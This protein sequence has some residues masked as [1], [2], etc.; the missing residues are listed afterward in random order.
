M[1]CDVR[2]VVCKMEYDLVLRFANII[3]KVINA[4]TPFEFVIGLQV[5]HFQNIQQN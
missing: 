5:I 4:P 1:L 3:F 2:T